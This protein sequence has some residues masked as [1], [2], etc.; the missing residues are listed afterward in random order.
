VK[1][2]IDNNRQAQQEFYLRFVQMM[3]GICLRYAANEAEAEDVLQE[4]FIQAFKK[5]DTYNGKGAL[6][7]WL[8][9][10]TVNKALEQYRKNK[11]IRNL[12]ESFAKTDLQ[13]TVDDS[14]FSQLELEELVLKIQQLPSGYR[15]VF[16]LYAIEG[17]THVEIGEL[18]GIAVGTS[19]SQYSRARK[20]LADMILAEGENENI[21][22]AYAKR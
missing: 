18:M 16:N 2:C 6:G 12:K 13:T 4:A 10:I 7:G 17:Y 1:V 3:K 14:V 22:L 19:K 11:S 20:M 15:A 21:R 5:L 9:R 8:R